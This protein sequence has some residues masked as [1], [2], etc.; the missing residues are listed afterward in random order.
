MRPTLPIVALIATATS[1]CAHAPPSPTSFRV[2]LAGHGRPVVLVPD[3]GASGE[4][5]DT[6]IAHLGGHFETHALTLPGFAGQPPVAGPIL[7][8]V[9]RELATYLRERHLR[10]AVIVGHMY[11]AALAYSLAI[12]EPELVGG[13]VVVDVLP[14]QS[15]L[16]EP[17]EP[18]ADA[19]KEAHQVHDELVAHP[20][21]AK[22]QERRLKRM[23][24]DPALARKLAEKAALSSG[25]A[26]ADAYL[27]LMTV[28]LREGVRK[29]QPSALVIVTDLTYPPEAWPTIEASWHRQV[30]PIP[31][32]ELVEIRGA[33]HYVMYDKPDEWFSA[34]DK[35]LAALPAQ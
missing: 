33:H 11:G 10:G 26:L 12:D 25:M 24:A 9:E 23:V 35:F 20:P 21:D 2:E 14:C 13:I 22:G 31:H 4:V 34:L 6:T 7:P 8:H 18:R 27:E 3:L 16:G 19:L 15:A 28:D 32:H 30:D 17:D 5:W 1:A 29:L